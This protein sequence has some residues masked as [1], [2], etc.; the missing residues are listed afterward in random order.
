[1]CPGTIT[2]TL[3]FKIAGLK[4]EEAV[5]PLITASVS[6]TSKTQLSGILTETGSSL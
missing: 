6:I 3:L 5:C 2:F 4:E 1:M